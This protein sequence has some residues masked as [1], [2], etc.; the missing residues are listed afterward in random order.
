MFVEENFLQGLEENVRV[1]SAI[2]TE[3][4]HPEVAAHELAR[5]WGIGLAT[6]TN[7]LR[8]TTQK[9]IRNVVHPLHRQYKTQQTQ[10][11]YNRLNTKVYSDTFFSTVKSVGGH[12]CGQIF[13]NDLEYS[14]FIPMEAERFAGDALSEFFQDVGVPTHI[15]TDGAKAL[16]RETGKRSERVKAV[17]SRQ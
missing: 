10:F 15:H 13:V 9:V 3:Q 12:T 14:K 7:T 1:T 8:A 11:R 5:K 4:R 16:T 2:K 6:A 17:S